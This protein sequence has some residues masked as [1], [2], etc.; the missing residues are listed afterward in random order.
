L[1]VNQ[2]P[3]HGSSIGPGP[4]LGIV[5]VAVQAVVRL[6]PTANPP[7]TATVLHARCLAVEPDDR[8]WQAACGKIS[9]AK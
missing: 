7:P 6:S 5:R 3:V 4:S 8:R 1:V 9:W 2:A